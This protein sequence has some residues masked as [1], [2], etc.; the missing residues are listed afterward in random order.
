MPRGENS[1]VTYFGNGRDQRRPGNK[2]AAKG[3]QWKDALRRQLA[4]YTDDRI[5]MGEALNEIAKVCVIQALAGD[6][7]ARQEIAN[8]LDGKPKETIDATFT[9]AVAQELTDEQLL[10][11]ARGSSDG[12]SETATGPED[13]SGIH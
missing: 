10:D 2:N 9:Q 11:I 3:T 7:D 4:Q 5:K 8:R 6:K 13:S 12:D 1:Q